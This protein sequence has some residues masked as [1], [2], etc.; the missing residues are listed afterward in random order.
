MPIIKNVVQQGTTIGYHEVNSVTISFTP[1]DTFVCVTMIGWADSQTKLDQEGRGG[2]SWTVQSLIDCTDHYNINAVEAA[3]I[4]SGEL[5]GGTIIAPPTP[6]TPLEYAKSRKLVSIKAA[7]EADL[8]SVLSTPYGVFQADYIS[9]KRIT[10]AIMMLQTLEAKGQPTTVQFILN[11]NSTVT[12][13]TD[14]MVNVGLILGQRTQMII[15]DASVKR[16]AVLAATT[17]EEVNAV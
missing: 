4:A 10:D 5:N 7:K 1:N 3:L 15:T 13:D 11:D 6:L 14:S 16:A 12:L 2:V 17:I 9:Q 8:Y